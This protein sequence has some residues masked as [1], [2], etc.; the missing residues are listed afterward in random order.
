MLNSTLEFKGRSA[1]RFFDRARYAGSIV[2]RGVGPCARKLKKRTP[3]LL[4]WLR[5]HPDRRPRQTVHGP[6]YVSE[7]IRK[8]SSALSL[9]FSLWKVP[10]CVVLS[11]GRVLGVQG[12][13][14]SGGRAL[15][16]Q[17]IHLDKTA[18][19]MQIRHAIHR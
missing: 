8:A 19:G 11:G 2:R 17:S 18:E 3:F 9:L 5:G 4:H 16:R 6:K 1:E 15:E 7:T 12:A 13:D 10:G 14:L